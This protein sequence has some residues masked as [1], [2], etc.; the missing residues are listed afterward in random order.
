MRKQFVTIQVA[1][2]TVLSKDGDGHILLYSKDGDY[3][4]SVPISDLYYFE[5]EQIMKLKEEITTLENKLKDSFDEKTEELETLE[6]KLRKSDEVRDAK[7][8]KMIANYKESMT[9]VFDMVDNIQKEV[10]K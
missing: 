10:S 3:Y 2:G 1:E 9:K 8:D 4:Y 6:G 5:D 7:V